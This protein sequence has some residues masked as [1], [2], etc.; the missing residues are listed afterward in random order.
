LLRRAETEP[1]EQEAAE[2]CFRRSFDVA[3]RQ[4]AKALELR[5]ALSASRL[6]NRQGRRAEAR[7]VLAE[8]YCWFT[9]GFNTPDLQEARALIEETA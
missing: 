5:A 2:T 7:K 4:Q 9:E 1:S 6:Y 3:H 8:T